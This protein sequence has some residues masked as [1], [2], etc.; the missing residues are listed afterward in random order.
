M[1]DR[2]IQ[3]TMVAGKP[4][5]TYRLESKCSGGMRPYPLLLFLV[6]CE[7][8][9]TARVFA[10]AERA[11]SYVTTVKGMQGSGLIITI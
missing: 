11:Y 1:H 2:S 3:Q 5:G 8:L 6:Q 10:R 7:I 9:S 4:T